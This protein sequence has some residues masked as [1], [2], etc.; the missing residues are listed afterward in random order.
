[1][2]VSKPGYLFKS[3][4]VKA[5]SGLSEGIKRDIELEPLR[6]GAAIVLNNLFFESGKSDLLPAS[7]AELKKMGKLMRNNPQL[8]I[9]ISG[10]TDNVGIDASNVLLSQKRAMAVTDNLQKQGISKIRL[11]SMGYGESKP[12]NDNADEEKRSRN[13]RIEFKVL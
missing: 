1:M 11:K 9:E 6:P 10:H 5:D 12:L 4:T 7:L 2:F 3:L 13:R 8:K